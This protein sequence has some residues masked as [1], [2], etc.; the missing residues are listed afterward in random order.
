MDAISIITSGCSAIASVASVI[1]AYKTFHF[2]RTFN[3]TV[4]QEQQKLSQRQLIIPL[5]EYMVALHE[6]DSSNPV[7]SDVIK[8]INAL[9]LIALC[10]EGGMIDEKV[11]L[12]TFS[13]QYILH[14]EAIK[15]TPKMSGRKKSGAELIKENK[16]AE[17]FY[18]KLNN[19]RLNTH[20]L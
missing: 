10:C 9:E 1:V 16:A 3:N 20:T 13:E 18:N 8:N 7:E 5:W 12:S 4:H 2:T 17:R 11:I 6:I 15:N 14:F 19:Q